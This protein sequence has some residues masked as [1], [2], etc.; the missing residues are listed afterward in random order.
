MAPDTEAIRNAYLA[1][2]GDRQTA[3]CGCH[4]VLLVML[5]AI[6][7]VPTFI[8]VKNAIQLSRARRD[9]PSARIRR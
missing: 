6:A 4:Y 5:V 7:A 1:I 8:A 2:F 3:S 9:F